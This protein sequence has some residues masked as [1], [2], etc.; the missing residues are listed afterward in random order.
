MPIL[1]PTRNFKSGIRITMLLL[2]LTAGQGGVNYVWGQTGPGAMGGAGRGGMQPPPTRMQ[3][4][5]YSG[6]SGTQPTPSFTPPTQGM[7][8]DAGSGFP[9]GTPA[10][11]LSGGAP[12]PGVFQDNPSNPLSNPVSGGAGQGRAGT[13][14]GAVSNS[15]AGQGQPNPQSMQNVA[16]QQP[17]LGSGAT[18]SA[19]GSRE[20]DAQNLKSLQDQAHPIFDIIVYAK[21][22][23]APQGTEKDVYLYEIL[24]GVASP[25][26][27]RELLK[28]YWNLCEKM[29]QCHVRQAQQQRL[30]HAQSQFQGNQAAVE[31][32]TLALQLVSQQYRALELEFT[33]AQYRFLDLQSKL[34]AYSASRWRTSY[35][36][37]T[38]AGVSCDCDGVVSQTASAQVLQ[39]AEDHQLPVP[40]DFPLAVPYDTK[41]EELKKRRTLSQ[42]SLL[43]D[44]TIPLQYDAVVARTAARKYADDRWKSTLQHGQSPVTQIEVLAQEEMAL[45]NTIIEYNHQVDDYVI[46][47][48]GTNIPDRQLL[49]SILVLP[50]RQGVETERNQTPRTFSTP[51]NENTGQ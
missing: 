33:Q 16:D 3:T 38:A 20:E 8:G 40:A 47:T 29:L 48:F 46:E 1:P 27:R 34:P 25:P 12:L 13:P 37:D 11:G 31:E 9:A 14:P 44:R 45:I 17:S 35:G 32:I 10:A 43:L 42:R 30:N 6:E 23:P 51:P 7:P 18:A 28:A 22:A 19:A 49:A 39:K 50:K 41:V 5:G 4:P 2:A 26:Q 15:D 24:S 21:R 36:A